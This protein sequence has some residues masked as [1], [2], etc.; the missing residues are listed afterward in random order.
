MVNF[1]VQHET[2]EDKIAGLETVESVIE[3]IDKLA[4]KLD[5]I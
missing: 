1:I 5:E 2:E 3:G 4:E